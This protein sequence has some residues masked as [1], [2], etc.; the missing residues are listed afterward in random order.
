MYDAMSDAIMLN[1][2]MS[3]NH[4]YYDRPGSVTYVDS[5]GGGGAVLAIVGIVFLVIIVVVFVAVA[6]GDF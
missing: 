2:L 6:K 3:R 5:G 1:A 4:Y